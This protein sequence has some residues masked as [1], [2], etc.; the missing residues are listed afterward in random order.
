MQRIYQ[1]KKI[2]LASSGSNLN[3]VRREIFNSSLESLQRQDNPRFSSDILEFN[4]LTE[5]NRA[6]VIKDA[7]RASLP[8]L[9]DNHILGILGNFKEESNLLTAICNTGTAFKKVYSGSGAVGLAQ[10]LTV[11]RFVNLLNS[12]TKFAESKNAE[13]HIL[14]LIHPVAQIKALVSELQT[15]EKRGF[16][17]FL[18]AKTIAEATTYW[19][20][21][22]E[23]PGNIS[24]GGRIKAAE[25]FKSLF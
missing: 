14:T 16:E 4:Q 10:W 7:L 6:A 18:K 9:S 8:V 20:K 2:L 5:K 22:I 25:T 17:N 19:M 1:A 13:D 15:S 3:V 12:A 24:A 23:R 11:D 21:Y